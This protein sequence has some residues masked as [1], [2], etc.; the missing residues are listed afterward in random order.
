MAQTK[1]IP[2]TQ[3]KVSEKVKEPSLYN[4]IYLNDEVTTVDFVVSTLIAVF[5]YDHV[6]SAE[7]T[8]KIHEYGSAVV[9]TYPYEIAEQKGVEVTLLARN[10]NFPLQVKL[11]AE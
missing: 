4:V 1:E 10:H 11:E 5:Q 6:K 9:A 7:I 8:Q 3:P 2:V